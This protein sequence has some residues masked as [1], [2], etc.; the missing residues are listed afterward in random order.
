MVH[1]RSNYLWYMYNS[2]NLGNDTYNGHTHTHVHTHTH[3]HAH[4]LYSLS[5]CEEG[6][7][8]QPLPSGH[9]GWRGGRLL[10]LGETAGIRVQVNK[11]T[12]PV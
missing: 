1:Y 2:P 6:D 5:D 3:A 9:D 7:R 8:D 10:L 12:C 11:P 4:T